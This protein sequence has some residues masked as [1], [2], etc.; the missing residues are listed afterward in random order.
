MT[1]KTSLSYKDAG[2]D[3]DAGNALVNRIKGVVKQTR[4]PEVMG[5]L[6]GF[7]ALCALPQKY[8]EPILVSGTDG[9]G[10]KLRLAMDLKRH[11]TIGID[12]VA[13]CVND[14]VV[15]GAEPLF[16]LDYYATGKLDVDTAASVISGIAEGCQLSGCALVGGETAEMPGMYHGEDYDVAGFC[17]GV[18][19]KSEIIDGSKVQAGDA[20][21]ALAASG[22]HSNGYSLIRKILAVSN[23]D[24]EATELESKSLADHLLAPTKIYV[25]SLLSLIEQV[26][27]HAIAHL[28]G[29]GFWENIPRVLPENTQAQ[30]NESS[31]QWPA[32]FNWLQQTGNVSRHEM[33]RT[34]NCGVGMVIALPP[35]AVEQA[36]ELLTAAGEKAWQIGTIATLKEGEQQV[37]IQ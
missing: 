24:P 17:V 11:D 3:I 33:Y 2:V 9:V 28:T 21:I 22:P 36:I 32:I 12:L 7:G 29:G 5:G 26:D 34:F 19:E 23:T 16:F 15:Q 25:K 1:N 20:L 27:I 30:I 8:R 31:W 10:T 6:G 18:V 4:R 14:L 37:V 35:T 13:M